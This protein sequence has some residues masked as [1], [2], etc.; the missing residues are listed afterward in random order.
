MPSRP[1]QNQTSFKKSTGGLD[2]KEQYNAKA[3]STLKALV[4]SLEKGQMSVESFG[5]W[6]EGTVDKFTFQV[7]VKDSES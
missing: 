6:Q 7:H 2:Y 4:R 3:I 5:W 1:T